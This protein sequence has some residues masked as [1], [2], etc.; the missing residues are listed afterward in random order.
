M[1]KRISF[2]IASKIMSGIL[3]NITKEVKDIHS[4]ILK[5]GNMRPKE[6]L[7]MDT[8]KLYHENDYYPK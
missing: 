8:A 5:H 2:S 6:V 3:I 4:E 7:P 1:R